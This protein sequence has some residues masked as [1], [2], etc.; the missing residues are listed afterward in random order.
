MGV[1]TMWS[2]ASL[3]LKDF[4]TWIS[5]THYPMTDTNRE[6][7][8]F[9]DFWAST[10]CPAHSPSWHLTEFPPCMPQKQ[11]TWWQK[12][13]TQKYRNN[14]LILRLSKIYM[15]RSTE[16]TFLLSN[17]LWSWE[18][19]RCPWRKYGYHNSNIP[20]LSCLREAVDLK[21]SCFFFRNPLLSPLSLDVH[22]QLAIS[23]KQTCIGNLSK[24]YRACTVE[25]R[26]QF[27]A[28]SLSCSSLHI[29]GCSLSE[30]THYRDILH[31]GGQIQLFI[32][33]V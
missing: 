29:T 3:E 11:V 8:H 31:F 26:D 1:W 17:L 6:C 30:V 15:C 21:Y 2:F 18:Q 24:I 10:A 19:A 25:F 16:K 23:W 20:L 14:L 33:C 4:M 5:S 27:P 13:Y 22:L 28:L 9:P 12:T 32:T 7:V